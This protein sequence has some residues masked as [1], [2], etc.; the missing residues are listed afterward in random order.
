MVCI[1]CTAVRF[2]VDEN[3]PLLMLIVDGIVIVF[4]SKAPGMQP[5][6][7]NP[8]MLVIVAVTATDVK[9]EMGED[10]ESMGVV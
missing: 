1:I 3:F 8:F 2:N 7:M 6:M 4:V 5:I 9:P 10:T